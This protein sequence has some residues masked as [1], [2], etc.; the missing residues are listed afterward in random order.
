MKILLCLLFLGLIK[1]NF[2]QTMIQIPLENDSS[3]PSFLIENMKSSSSETLSEVIQG[4]ISIVADENNTFFL[5]DQIAS[6]ILHYDESGILLNTIL[7]ESY[8]KTAKYLDMAVY[9]KKQ[10]ILFN[11]STRRFSLVHQDPAIQPI[12]SPEIPPTLAKAPLLFNNFSL[13]QDKKKLIF[14]NQFNGYFYTTATKDLFLGKPIQLRKIKNSNVSG[15]SPLYHKNIGFIAW[16]ES[17]PDQHEIEFSHLDSSRQMQKWFKSTTFNNFSGLEPLSI[18]QNRFV[19]ALF[20]GGE[21]AHSLKEIRIVN[22]THPKDKAQ[23]I[24]LNSN[25]LP[26]YTS[27]RICSNHNK[28]YIMSYQKK[29]RSLNID[30]LS[31]DQANK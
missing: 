30:I 24:L 15:L 11:E 23:T 8:D 17:N 12:I 10:L 26:W 29:L 2:S 9:Q 14:Q 22:S 7:L 28:L 27:R 13:S 16:K 5:L 6:K 31:L 1:I 21:S 20:S 3:H 4:P 18:D 25:Q 19:F